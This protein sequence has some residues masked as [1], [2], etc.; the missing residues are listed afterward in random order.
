MLVN[1]M[2]LLLIPKYIL[3]ESPG[4]SFTTLLVIYIQKHIQ[5]LWKYSGNSAFNVWVVENGDDC[6]SDNNFV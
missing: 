1:L 2:P 3:L 6:N 5:I 4:L